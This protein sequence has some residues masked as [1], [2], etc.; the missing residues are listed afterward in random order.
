[1]DRLTVVMIRASLCWLVMGMCLGGLMLVDRAIP[2]YWRV[3]FAAT[4]G[5]VLFVGWFLQFAIAVA[6]WLFPRKRTPE[7]PNGYSEAIGL[8]SA[9]ALNAGLVFRVVCEP[10]ESSGHASTITL[11]GLEFSAIFQ[12]AAVIVFASQLWPR[13]ATRRASTKMRQGSSPVAR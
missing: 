8:P 4:H 11:V 2:G 6:Y 10:L 13:V 12:V 7:R 5:H 1:M 9:L 3:W